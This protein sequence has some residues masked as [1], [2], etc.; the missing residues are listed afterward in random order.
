MAGLLLPPAAM[1]RCSKQG[2]LLASSAPIC[3]RQV[4]VVEIAVK[5][6]SLVQKLITIVDNNTKMVITN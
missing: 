5:I 1:E 3:Q 6:R 4:W 2:K